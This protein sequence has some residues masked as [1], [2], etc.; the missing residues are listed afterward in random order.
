MAVGPVRALLAAHFQGSLR[1][2]T[3]EFTKQGVWA[4]VLMVAVMACFVLVPA[5]FGLF[6]AGFTLA[7]RLAGPGDGTATLILG[8]LLAI[9]VGVGGLLGALLGG[10]KKLSWEQYRTFPIGRL[11]LLGA[12]L[13]AGLGDLLTGLLALGLLAFSLG[14]ALGRPAL[15]PLLPLLFLEH[16]VLLMV[17]Q[18][19]LGSLALRVAKRLKLAVGLLLGAA[20]LG[21][22]LLTLVEPGR[23]HRM[24]PALAAVLQ[25]AASHLLAFVQA[26]PTTL[27]VRGLEAGG[28]GHWGSALLLQLPLL[29]GTILLAFGAMRLL[30]REQE[31]LAPVAGRGKARLWSFRTPLGGLA[32]LQLRTLLSSHHGKFGFL[33]PL[34]TVVLLKGPMARS[35][36]QAL[37]ALP[38]AFAYLALFGNQFQYN[39]F[40]LDGHGVKS[41]FLLPLGTRQIL[42]G[43][44][45]GYALYQG[46]QAALLIAM[47]LPLFHPSLPE[48]G[49]S[50]ALAVCFFLVQ[51][52]IGSFTSGWMPRRIDRT[53]L[54]N[55]QMP[56][57]L[58]LLGL[59]VSLA[60]AVLFGGSYALLAWLEPA[61]LLPGMLAWAALCFGIHRLLMPQ[62]AAYLDR[63]REA[64]VEAMG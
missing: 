36:G 59:G 28:T 54:K 3:R 44:L 10:S 62:A 61:F 50:L 9:L 57:P 15:L 11:R 5:G 20:W 63:R 27:A 1:R 56:L 12:E 45:R 52:A 40:G 30:E 18:L 8:A 34:L 31:A 64:I 26:L 32:R 46:L 14:L 4:L 48:L 37:W 49:A 29:G 39:Q 19:L 21:S 13:I 38:G 55:N 16:L 2:S 7:P 43:K 51:S 6:M 17:L 25:G 24:P 47:L 22:M 42:D 41:L 60:S 23:G 53:T 58:V 35:H 33:M